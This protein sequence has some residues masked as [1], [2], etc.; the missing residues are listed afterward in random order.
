MCSYSRILIIMSQ[1]LAVL[2]LTA[3]TFIGVYLYFYWEEKKKQQSRTPNET[4][5]K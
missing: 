2:G 5:N 4:K 1:S 3:C